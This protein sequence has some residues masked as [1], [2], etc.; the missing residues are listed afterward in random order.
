MMSVEAN[1]ADDMAQQVQELAAKQ[2]NLSLIPRIYMA[3]KRPAR[4]SCLLT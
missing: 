2:D 4:A 1:G 3:E